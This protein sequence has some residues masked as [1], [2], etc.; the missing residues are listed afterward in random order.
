MIE[1]IMHD[2]GRWMFFQAV[3]LFAFTLGI[4]KVTHQDEADGAFE[5]H[6]VGSNSIDDVTRLG[7]V[8]RDLYFSLFGLVELDTY[9][10]SFAQLSIYGLYL[11]LSVVL[12]LNLLIAML[13]K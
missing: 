12:L 5:T 4:T 7:Y 6:G 9:S 13:N 8:A 1:K 10:N 11:I 3:L 2:L